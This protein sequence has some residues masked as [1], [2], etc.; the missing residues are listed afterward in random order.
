MLHILSNLLSNAI[1]YSP[2]DKKISLIITKNEKHI[3]LEVVDEGIGIPKNEHKNIFE[4]F[5]RAKN[6]VNIQG[7]GLGLNIVKQNTELMGGT[8]SFKSKL[9]KGTSFKVELPIK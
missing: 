4:R 5:F 8:I 7:T 2:K 9:N 1:K 6:S 3:T